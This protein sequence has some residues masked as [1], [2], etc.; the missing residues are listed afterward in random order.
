[1]VCVFCVPTSHPPRFW[2]KKVK[3]GIFCPCR[4]RIARKSA[5]GPIWYDSR[6]NAPRTDCSGALTDAPETDRQT[7]GDEHTWVICPKI[8]LLQCGYGGCNTGYGTK[9][10]SSKAQLGQ[11]T[12]GLGCCL[13]S[14][15]FLCYI[16]CSHS[17]LLHAPW[18]RT[19][20]LSTNIST[21]FE[22]YI[23]LQ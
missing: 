14:L 19:K 15:H 22:V 16:L 18:Q 5:A 4:T 3:R 12:G 8:S 1:M 2:P 10:S 13:V 11:A 17:V 7:T 21:L 20:K 6:G 9:I 23:C